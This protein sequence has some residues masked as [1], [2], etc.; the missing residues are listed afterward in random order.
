MCKAAIDLGASGHFKQSVVHIAM[1]PTLGG[2]FQVLAGINIALYHAINYHRGSSNLTL[3][4]AL[5]DDSYKRVLA[6]LGEN[7][8]L[9][10]P[11][12]VQAPAE[13][14]VTYNRCVPGYERSVAARSKAGFC[15]SQHG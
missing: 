14:H 3:Y 4:P 8:A 13:M 5:V 9:Y 15:I 2:Q 1:H 12:D 7:I 11:F 6:F 10:Y